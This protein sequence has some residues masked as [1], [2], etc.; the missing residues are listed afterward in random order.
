MGFSSETCW[1]KVRVTEELEMEK[2]G[3]WMA[4]TVILGSLGLKIVKKMM[5]ITMIMKIKKMA[6]TTHDVR[7]GLPEADAGGLRGFAI[8]RERFRDAW[9]LK[10]SVKVGHH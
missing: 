7:F 2:E 5:R 10:K 1:E 3:S 9:E 4:V 6:A 8:F